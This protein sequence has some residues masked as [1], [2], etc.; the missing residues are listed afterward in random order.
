MDM[1]EEADAAEAA[2][3][4]SEYSFNSDEAA[5]MAANLG[6]GR[7]RPPKMQQLDKAAELARKRKVTA[8]RQAKLRAALE[9]VPALPPRTKREVR[10]VL[11]N[12]DVQVYT[13]ENAIMHVSIFPNQNEVEK[14]AAEL[15]E[16]LGWA[17]AVR[18]TGSPH[19]TAVSTA[20]PRCTKTHFTQLCSD[21]DC[22]YIMDCKRYEKEDVSEWRVVGF[23]PHH[24]S[25]KPA[26]GSM[27]RHCHFSTSQ[28]VPCVLDAIERNAYSVTIPQ[29]KALLGV[30]VSKKVSSDLASRVREAALEQL[31]GTSKENFK[32][33]TPYFERLC[34]LGYAAT[35]QTIT[36]EEMDE[37]IRLKAESNHKN[38]QSKLAKE[39]RTALS[40]PGDTKLSTPGETYLAGWVITGFPS[41]RRML[42]TGAM[43]KTRVADFAFAKGKA[44]GNYGFVVTTDADRRL[45]PLAAA[46]TIY[47]ETMETWDGLLEPACASYG[48]HM[49][50]NN[51]SI[52]VTD[53]A[54]GAGSALLKRNHRQFICD[55]HRGE[56]ATKHAMTAAEYR[57]F[58]RA[59]TAASRD[60]LLA[61]LSEKAR[62]WIKMLPLN[63]QCMIEVPDGMLHGDPTSNCAESENAAMEVI[64]ECT[65]PFTA[66]RLVVQKFEE[67]HFKN[68]TDAAACVDHATPRATEDLVTLQLEAR[69]LN[70]R[71]VV[72]D[73][74]A[75]KVLVYPSATNPAFFFTVRLN[76]NN[77]NDATCTCGGPLVN[78]RLCIHAVAACEAIRVSPHTFVYK[79]E[80]TATWQLQ[81][82]AGGD[83]QAPEWIPPE[84]LEEAPFLEPMA[85]SAGRGR[86]RTSR[87]PGRF[88]HAKKAA[89]AAARKRMCGTLRGAAAPDAEP[90]AAPAP[91]P[92]DALEPDLEASDAESEG[93]RFRDPAHCPGSEPEPEAEP[94]REEAEPEE[95]EPEESEPEAPAYEFP[96]ANLRN[97]A[98]NAAVAN[99]LA[100]AQLPEPAS[101]A[102][103]APT[104]APVPTPPPVVAP[105]RS[106][107]RPRAE[108][109]T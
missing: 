12:T 11:S 76:R 99:R 39:E 81:Y 15:N 44:E 59:T 70:V 14:R 33:L 85:F 94:E 90:E 8:Q 31:F 40:W 105:R 51:L 9:D 82:A 91:E 45:T 92:A 16:H 100:F 67:A 103:K 73:E 62:R 48:Q 20:Q 22:G 61:Q 97:P 83:F 7:G 18:C 49:T 38:G 57:D 10:A 87:V 1:F 13:A 17:V 21:P 3:A 109:R 32:R 98:R 5:Y 102:A 78:H 88:D 37:V 55:K 27:P 68:G 96:A 80:L 101:P 46:W 24:P 36:S 47:D 19:K 104:T 58:S 30:Y 54:K 35:I 41:T 63:M 79:E 60:R 53:A 71:T 107:R 84:N 56:S 6:K 52:Y 65:C 95:S 43:N 34:D 29:V 2:E 72:Q 23:V 74:P 66:A 89:R 4:A 108:R 77:N 86:K 26:K 93:P 42:E 69:S 25:C 28:L 64:R 106:P 75:G 50:D